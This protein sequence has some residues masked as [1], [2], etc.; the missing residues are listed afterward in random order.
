MTR[1]TYLDELLTDNPLAYWALGDSI[2][3]IAVN[4]GSL[5]SAVTA[6]Y[7]GG[8]TLGATGLVEGTNTAA[9]FDGVNDGLLIGNHA[10]INSG[11]SYNQR[12]IELWFQADTFGGKRM[13]YDEGGGGNGFNIYL[14]GNQLKLGAWATNVGSWLTQEVKTHETYHVVLVFDQ[15]TLKG[16]VN[17]EL[18][19][20]AQT[21]F[22][23]LPAHG[24]VSIGQVN[25][26]TRWS[27]TSVL[28]GSGAYFDG[29]IDEVSLYNT[30][31]SGDRVDAHYTAAG[32][33]NT[34]QSYNNAL[35]V[36]TDV[37]TWEAAQTQ[38]QQWGGNLVTINHANEETW[39]KETFGTAESFWTGLTD[40]AVEGTF[41]WISGETSTYRNFA[42][43]EPNNSGGNEDYVS[44]N[45]G[46]QKQ[47]N[48]ANSNIA[49]RGV[50]E[51]PVQH[52]NGHGYF[53]SGL[54][55][56]EEVRAMAERMG[57]RL[58]TMTDAA[59]EA[60]L[61]Q[62]FGEAEAFWIGLT[63]KDQEADGNAGAFKWTSGE[64]SSYRN[65]A[66]GE[67]N[68]SG[69][70]EDYVSMNWGS[71]KKWN[72]NNNTIRLRGIIEVRSQY[73][74]HGT[75]ANNTLSGDASNN[76]I[77]GYAGND[78]LFGDAGDDS[79]YG[80]SGSD[81]L[82]GNEGIDSLT[83]GDGADYFLFGSTAEGVDTV[84]DFNAAQGDRIVVRSDFGATDVTDFSFNPATATLS[85]QG[86]PFVKLPGVMS[87]D[88]ATSIIIPRNMT[89]RENS[90]GATEV[91]SIAIGNPNR[92][93]SFPYKIISGNSSGAFTIDPFTGKILVLDRSQLNYED[94]KRH[95]LWIEALDAVGKTQLRVATIQ[96]RD[97]NEAP[98]V[99]NQ[100]FTVVENSANGVKVGQ[101]TA[102]DPDISAI[103]NRIS[104]Q[105]ING[106]SNGAFT[107]NYKTGEIFL[108]KTEL[109]DYE[110][111]VSHPLT[112]QV[113]DSGGLKDT[114]EVTI[115][116][117]DGNDAPTL[118]NKTLYLK[119]V[120]VQIGEGSIIGTVTATD[121]NF[122]GGGLTY[123]ITG[124]NDQEYFVIDSVTGQIKA[125]PNLSNA[126]MTSL[127]SSNA[128]RRSLTVKATDAF[129]LSSTATVLLSNSLLGNLYL[130]SDSNNPLNQVNSLNW[131]VDAIPMFADM[132]NDGDV[133]A[134]ISDGVGG[135]H[136][137][138]NNNGTFTQI[139]GSADPLDG[140]PKSNPAFAD[141][142]NDGDL[143]A[144][145][146]NGKSEGLSYLKNNNGTFTV[147]S[148]AGLPTSGDF[149]SATADINNDGKVD[150][151]TGNA[152]GTLGYYQNN[153]NGSVTQKTGTLNPFN[154]FDVGDKARPTFAD[155]DNDGDADAVVGAADGKLYVFQNNGNGS[156]TPKTGNANPFNGIDVGNN[157]A[158][159]LADTDNNGYLDL[160]IG[161]SE[162]KLTYYKGAQTILNFNLSTSGQ[163]TQMSGSS[164]YSANTWQ[165]FAPVT[166]D[167]SPSFD[168]GF[169]EVDLETD[170]SFGFKA[171]YEVDS[172]TVNAS[173]PFEVIMNGP[174][175]IADGEMV[176]FSSQYSMLSNASFSTSTPHVSAYAGFF[177]DMYLGAKFSVGAKGISKSWDYRGSRGLNIDDDSLKLT[178]DSRDLGASYSSLPGLDIRA[179]SPDI[180]VQGK[181]KG[182]NLLSGSNED[183]FL[184]TEIS[185]D[186]FLV[187]M[188]DE[189]GGSAG[190][191][192][193]NV[194][195]N[196]VDAVVAGVEWD[197]LDLD[198][199]GK[200]SLKQNY[201][202]KFDSLTGLMTLENGTT[203]TF[204]VGDDLSF[205]YTNSMD[206]NGNG[207]LDYTLDLSVKNPTLTNKLDMVFDLDFEIAA[208]SGS[209][210]YDVWPFSGSK[211]FGPL[212]SESFD[213]AKASMNIYNKTFSL[214]GFNTQSQVGSIAIG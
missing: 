166:W 76:L 95:E 111:K 198:L 96:V 46:S 27:N 145:V 100:S 189:F 21:N 74:V 123:S 3:T 207:K 196:D 150:L 154:G 182:A 25:G 167:T 147:T 177:L 152:D 66:T 210:W 82:M 12:T 197:L 153:G 15:G 199:N 115:N 132:D 156:F 35:Y 109:L 119:D 104:Y 213:L 118:K 83:G 186:D 26:D 58:V 87:F 194:W 36:L 17:N 130:Q 80:G 51:I 43:G 19:G 18:I 159:A 183:T 10:D 77:Y 127:I 32:K 102:S 185:V 173:L 138:Q 7:S 54:G 89:V 47:W 193:A 30:A 142:D 190:K 29:T 55:T 141:V 212:Y 4:Q 70:N 110:T 188:L 63:D 98:V 162:G 8:T 201:D 38:A 101:V 158:P 49:A 106:N 195:Q 139:L 155:I 72:D 31:L 41:Q 131:G 125:N 208:V 65:F 24:G 81:K 53:L 92:M 171:G 91:G 105:I 146:G 22:T 13:I 11:T 122:G 200:L 176:T 180:A 112:I 14:D 93:T 57:G 28:A 52:Y 202:L 44:M 103:N 37:L 94:V 73:E 168:L 78:I 64:E 5:G 161:N 116:L 6:T 117:L 191:A 75:A 163:S 68:D 128:P 61:K 97:V 45:Y 136:Y 71:Q 99:N 206:S 133:D 20:T 151:I 33:L 169:L 181:T 174:Q 140:I 113:T 134:V 137:F 120:G 90:I 164:A 214:G 114:A 143:D 34:T 16:Y 69:G 179:S 126:A 121:D 9:N 157:S 48:D 172:G 148:L 209:A 86:A 59:E 203:K 39:L 40:K 42:A 184:E 178:F 67:P 149:F 107:I 79:I 165:P 56:W 204:N 85:F 129:G 124:G 160:V 175:R 187:Y 170:G 108:A 192:I 23:A 2:G 1:K 211:D 62:T 84:T 205:V 88:L 135:H 144:F 50:V 60:W